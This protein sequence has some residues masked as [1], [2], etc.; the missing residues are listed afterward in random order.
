M[1]AS[2]LDPRSIAISTNP[3]RS[4]ADRRVSSS[5]IS[6]ASGLVAQRS[7]TA[8][9]WNG[10]GEYIAEVRTP[11]GAVP[12]KFTVVEWVDAA[13]PV[14]IFH[15]GSGD[16]PYYARAK[17]AWAAGSRTCTTPA[18]TRPTSTDR[19]SPA[20]RS[21]ACSSILRIAN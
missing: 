9:D 10:K 20:L 16:I 1:V 17:K 2:R 12:T 5:L 18:M 3:R 14:L 15:H 19:S 4:S 7:A 11:L 6:A 21:T 8:P 13:A